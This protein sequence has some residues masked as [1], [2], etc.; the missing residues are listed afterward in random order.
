MKDNMNKNSYLVSVEKQSDGT[1]IA[2]NKECTSTAIGT[3]NSVNEA[4]A[5]FRNTLQ[6]MKD[7]SEEEGV[8]VPDVCLKEPVFKFD[9]SSLL[10]YYTVL[11]ATAFA[12][13]IGL[14]PT[15][16]RQYKR[17]GTYISTNQ[18]KRIED[19]LHVLANE[20]ASVRLV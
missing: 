10:E 4:I 18:L 13:R 9:V 17:G 2:Y 7:F 20:L 8:P 12:K 15:L 1:Y 16:L 6:E 14:N 19:G 3:G 5:D 11:N